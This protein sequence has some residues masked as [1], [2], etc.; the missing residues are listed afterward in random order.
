[1]DMERHC[2][3]KYAG[4]RKTDNRAMLNIAGTPIPRLAAE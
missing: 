4:H 1:M 2:R 3:C